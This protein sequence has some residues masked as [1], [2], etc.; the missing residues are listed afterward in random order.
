MAFSISIINSSVMTRVKLAF[1]FI[2]KT[3]YFNNKFSIKKGFNQDGEN[4]EEKFENQPEL[5]LNC[6][7]MAMHHVNIN[8]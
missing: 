6:F 7:G 8:H 1:S 5:Y 3:S 2:W 4:F